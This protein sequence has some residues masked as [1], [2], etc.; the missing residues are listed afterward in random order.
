M[1]IQSITTTRWSLDDLLPEPVEDSLAATL[2]ELEELTASFEQQREWLTGEMTPSDLLGMLGHYESI[3]RLAYRIYAHAQLYFTEDTKNP[4]ALN[5]RDRVEQAVTDADNRTLFFTLWLKS[6]SDEA[7]D[8]L[9]PESGDYRHYIQTLRKFQPHTLNESEEQI[10]NL[11]NTNGIGALVNLYDMITSGF[12]FNVEV[13]GEQKTLT[14]D[15]V[16]ALYR[17]PSPDVRAAAYQELFRVYD[18]NSAVLSQMYNHRVR[19]WNAEE[20][21]LRKYASP[22]AAR[23]L[24]NDIPDEAVEALLDV[25]ARNNSVF[26]RYFQLKAGWLG[27][28]KLRRYDIYA[29]LVRADKTYDFS[30]AYELVMDG[31][32]HFS[33]G[34]AHLAQRVFAENHIDSEVRPGKRGGAFCY[35]V[36]PGMTPWVMVNYTGQAR[37]VST[38]AHELG[39]AI[40]GMLAAERSLLTFHPSL[41][42]AETASV[43]SEMLLTDRLLEEETDPAVLRDILAGAIDDAYATVQRQAYFTLFER[44]AHGRIMAGERVADICDRYLDNLK[45]QFGDAVVV[46]EDFRWEWIAIPHIYHT[47]FYTYAYSF[48]QLLVLSLYQQYRD[49][50]EAFIPRYVNLLAYGGSEEPARVLREAGSDIASADFWQGGYDV[51]SGMVNRLAQL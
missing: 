23:N 4:A 51:L 3:L 14:R 34:V 18:E 13:D 41:P 6:L 35:S 36:V 37:D 45:A 46:S 42:L 17:H 15:Q 29:P 39:H 1:M 25:S 43:F 20:V 11:K 38:L 9:M 12:T 32:A 16:A 8:R 24:V 19:D 27:V 10:I 48:G 28:D 26:Q 2:A 50:G 22:I 49:Q 44:E 47:P 31:L 30:Q 5:L 40:H 7:A 33:P 21:T